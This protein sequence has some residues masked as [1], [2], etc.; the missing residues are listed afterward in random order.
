MH[1][2]TRLPYLHR[3][4]CISLLSLPQKS[5]TPLRRQAK[6]QVESAMRLLHFDV[7]GRLFLTDFRGKPVPPYAILSHRWGD[8]EALIEDILDGTYE[9]K[10]EGYLKLKFCAEQAKHDGLQYF[11][12]DTCCID[13]W[14]TNERSKAINS[15]FH[16]YRNAARCYV[17]LLDMSLTAVTENALYSDWEASFCASLWF[18]RGWTL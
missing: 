7:L 18:T 17:F 9:E 2:P 6:L 5:L 13:R 1:C 12:I 14:D 4:S 15:M 16:W 10:E 8:S 11:W 3:R